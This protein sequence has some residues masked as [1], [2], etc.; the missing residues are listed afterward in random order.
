MKWCESYLNSTKSDPKE[1]EIL[2]NEVSMFYGLPGFYWGIWAMIQSELSNIEFDYAKYGKL[3]LGEYWD[4]KA[5][6]RNLIESVS[7]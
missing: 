7:V 1:I 5:K 2:I 6:N 3:R 4:W